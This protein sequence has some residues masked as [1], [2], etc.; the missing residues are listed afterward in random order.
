MSGEN[1]NISISVKALEDL[2][3]VGAQYHAFDLSAGLLAN[4]GYSAGGIIMGRPASGDPAQIGVMGVMKFAAGGGT[5][6]AGARLTVTTSGWFIT[7]TSGL[8]QVGRNGDTAITSG[9]IGMGVFAFNAPS[10]QISSL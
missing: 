8:Y 1:Q 5:I 7:C 6:A 3:A 9:S 10:W 2:S 4:N